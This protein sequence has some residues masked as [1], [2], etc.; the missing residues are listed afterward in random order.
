VRRSS[1]RTRLPSPCTSVSP[2]RDSSAPVPARFWPRVT[3]SA[4]SALLVK[5]PASFGSRWPCASKRAYR[6]SGHVAT[7]AASF[8][9]LTR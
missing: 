8:P 5:C 7:S 1:S 3:S 9:H 4:A 6:P 2:E